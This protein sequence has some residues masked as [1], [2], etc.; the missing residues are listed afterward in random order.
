MAT[1][2]SRPS[3]TTEAPP[4]PIDYL[5]RFLA[6]GDPRLGDIEECYWRDVE[7]YGVGHAVRKCRNDVRAMLFWGLV[8]RLYKGGAIAW[9]FAKIREWTELAG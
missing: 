4:P 2:Q 9:L 3:A 1:E 8:E 6:S 5:V 7:R